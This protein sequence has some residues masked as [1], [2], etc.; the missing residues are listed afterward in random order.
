MRQGFWVEATS[1]CFNVGAGDFYCGLFGAAELLGGNMANPTIR[2]NKRFSFRRDDHCWRLLESRDGISRKDKDQPVTTVEATYHPTLERL[3]NAVIDRSVG[4]AA[5]L[6]AIIT[7]MLEVQKEI[8]E[9][10]HKI[11][12]K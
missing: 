10:L 9:A 12:H 4:N 6:E 5:S 3:F 11:G 8:L 7:V 1:L 2:I